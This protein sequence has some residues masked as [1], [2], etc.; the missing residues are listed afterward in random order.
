MDHWQSEYIAVDGVRL[1]YTRTGAGADGTKPPIVLAHGFSDAGL[2]WTPVAQALEAD[3]DVIMVDARGHGLSDAPETGY[4]PAEHA[5]D[6][7]GVITQLGLHRPAVLGHSMGGATA[8]ALAGMHPRVPR[9]LVIEDAAPLGMSG[10]RAPDDARR[11]RVRA[12]IEDLKRKSIAELIA[13][14]RTEAPRWSDAELGPWADAKLRVSLNVLNAAP[15]P[16][17]DWPVVLRR[18]ACPALLLTADPE[19]GAGVTVDRAAEMQALIAQLRVEHVPDAGHSIRRDQ[20]AR[21]MTVVRAFLHATV[22]PA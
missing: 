6:L 15:S 9:A 12:W 5:F 2:C 10:T 19:R 14:Q 17:L 4:G 21:Y 3:Y 18:I 11:A 7:Y 8:L 1:H 13:H 16:P 22:T 20:F